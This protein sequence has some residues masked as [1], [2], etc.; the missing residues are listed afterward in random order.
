MYLDFESIVGGLIAIDGCLA[1]HRKRLQIIWL[2]EP[3]DK[4]SVNNLRGLQEEGRRGR[5]VTDIQLMVQLSQ[6]ET[7]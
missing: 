6:K 7:S 5:K 4:V 3:L 2:I 1:G